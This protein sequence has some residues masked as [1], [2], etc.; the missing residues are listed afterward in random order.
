[1]ESLAKH[2]LHQTDEQRT[3]QKR[4]ALF[5]EGAEVLFVADDLWVVCLTHD[6]CAGANCHSTQTCVHAKLSD[7]R[8]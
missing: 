4:M 8:V 7:S 3:A 2:P 6:P 1:M 5:P